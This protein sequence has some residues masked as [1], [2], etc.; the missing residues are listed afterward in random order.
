AASGSGDGGGGDGGGGEGGGGDGG[1]GDGGGGDGG[2]GVGG[3]GGGDPGGGGGGGSGGAR[4]KTTIDG[5]RLWQWYWEHNKDRYFARATE[6]GRVFRG[7]AYYWFGAGAKYPPRD[8][9]PVSQALRESQIHAAITRLLQDGDAGVRAEACIAMGRLGSAAVGEKERKADLPNDRTVRA[10]AAVLERDTGSTPDSKVVRQSALLGLGVCGGDEAGAYLLALL[11]KVGADEKAYV[12][13][14]LGLA[15]YLPAIPTLIEGLPSSARGKLTDEQLGCIHALGLYGPEAAAE[16]DA[17]GGMA[18]LVKIADPRGSDDASS[19][20]AVTA[21]GRLQWS[22]DEV[23]DVFNR[24]K[25]PDL[26][27]AAVLA[28]ANYAASEKDAENAAK[29]LIGDCFKTGEGQAKSFSLLAAGDLAGRLDSN[30]KTREKIL[31]H[32]RKV[33]DTKDNYLRSCAAVGL[34]LA[35]DLSAV[36]AIVKMLQDP[37]SNQHAVSAGCLALGLLRATEQTDHIRMSVMERA[38][39]ADSRG[40]AALGIALMGDTT[41]IDD[42]RQFHADKVLNVR[43]LRQTGL[44]LGVLGG[45][46]EV[47][48]IVEVFS[49]AWKQ[50]ERYKV[51]NAA[52]ALSWMRDESAVNDLIKLAQSSEKELRGMAAIALGYVGARDAVSPLTRCFEN[53]S[54]RNGF[55]WTV[56]RQIASIL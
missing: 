19:C 33:V 18:R 46:G 45:K 40:Y 39:D 22:F 36:P 6:R 50:F 21:L 37:A 4:G 20:Q 51:S 1:G 23:R 11:P 47:K 29:M 15:R 24:A 44:A 53:A 7:S 3:G 25:S 26:M 8:L 35:R 48:P 31:D 10:L 32:L 49:A 56:L 16:I 14:A 41:R 52:F 27:W 17:K 12:A 54:F 2:G 5:S 42:L 55:L 28:M 34:G 30:S 13:I 38:A 43:T 9:N